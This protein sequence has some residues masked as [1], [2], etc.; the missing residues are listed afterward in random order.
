MLKQVGINVTIKLVDWSTWISQVYRDTAYDLTV[1]GHTGQLD[2]HGRLGG[3]IGY[4]NYANPDTLRLI[5]EAAGVSDPATRKRLYAD[6]QRLMAEDAMM[7]FIGTPTVL[8]G[9]RRNIAG[10]RMSYAL[11]DPI[12]RETFHTK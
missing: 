3:E 2:P 7:G 5:A 6:V 9:L 10:F 1:I 4:T 12:F 11:E 8:M